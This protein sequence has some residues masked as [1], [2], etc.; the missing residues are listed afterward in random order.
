[1]TDCIWRSVN[2]IGEGKSQAAMLCMH[3]GYESNQYLRLKLSLN[4]LL[5]GKVYQHC[6]RTGASYDNFVSAKPSGPAIAKIADLTADSLC[7]TVGLDAEPQKNL[8]AS[9]TRMPDTWELAIVA[10]VGG[11]VWQII[12]L[13]SQRVSRYECRVIRY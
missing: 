7:G 13:G 11:N 3:D 12:H 5:G 8:L 9:G 2:E 4:R 1:M 6:R 10:L